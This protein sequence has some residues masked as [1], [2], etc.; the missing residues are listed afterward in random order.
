MIM[1]II[2]FTSLILISFLLS[3]LA[4]AQESAPDT[5]ASAFEASLKS[6]MQSELR[7]DAE[8]ERDRNRRP[9]E[10]LNFFGIQSDMKVLELIPG[11]GW[12][13]KLL[14]PALSDNGELYVAIGAGR[15]KERVVGQPGFEKI[16]VLEPSVNFSDGNKPRLRTVNTFSFGETG[17]DAILTFRNMHN[18]DDVGRK[19]INDASFK[20]LK[21]GGIYG[22]VD[23]TRRHME[24]FTAENRRRADPV[25][26]IKE[27]LDSGFELVD[28][29]DIHYRA[30]DELRYEVGRKTVT[31]NTDRFTLKFRKPVK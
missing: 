19:N 11:G 7:T 8:K 4:S 3:S 28:F 10:T 18:F 21:P 30:D 29:S 25:E 23:H 1:R 22:V 20:A 13:T 9:V 27:V 6:A 14:A 5:N 17:F 16:K 15:V 31:G 24:P 26:I 2:K 12:Y